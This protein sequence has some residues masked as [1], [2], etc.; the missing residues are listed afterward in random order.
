[1]N[2]MSLP[3]LHL[4]SDDRIASIKIWHVPL[5][6]HATYYMAAGKTC[7]T[8]ETVVVALETSRGL[9]GWGEVCPIPHYL[10][11]YAR[12]VAPAIAELKEI[13]LGASPLGP[14]ALY[15]KMDAWLPGHRYAKSAVDIAAWDLFAKSAGL[16]LTALLGG[17]QSTEFPVYHSLTCVAP[18]EMVRMAREAQE[19]GITLFQVKLGA[20][21][22]W[23]QDVERL[24]AIRAAVG[25]GPLVY[26]DWNC[27]VTALHATR[28]GRGVRD[29]DIMLE[30]PCKT[31]S[32]CA[33]VREATGLA[34]KLDENAH[35]I[36]SL[37]EGHRS[38]CMDVMA[39]K[40]SKFGGITPTRR[41]RDLCAHLG[42]LMCVE[43]TWGSDIVTCAALHLAASSPPQTVLTVCD[44]SGYVGPRLDPKAP[45]RK[46]GWISVPTDTGLGVH[47]DLSLLGEPDLVLE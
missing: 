23:Q 39:L 1:M 3:L 41:A 29:L 14:E 25:D 46:D 45:Q 9:V 30:Q 26:G 12:G 19:A 6:S 31:I 40:I 4:G 32:E 35:D 34:M 16:P 5:T 11:A 47:P 22:D 44:L 7:A 38:G 13:I 15:Q 17:V 27:G 10:P 2:E 21:N 37:L 43:D 33:H 36:D 24:K 8:V 20:D 42:T 18:D 28:V